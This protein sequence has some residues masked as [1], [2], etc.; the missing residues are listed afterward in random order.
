LDDVGNLA[1]AGD[2]TGFAGETA[3]FAALVLVLSAAFLSV[4]HNVK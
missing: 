1:F 4:Y 3:G 2:A